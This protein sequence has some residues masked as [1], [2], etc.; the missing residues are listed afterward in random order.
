M[1]CVFLLA[2]WSTNGL[3][4][5][6]N[7]LY[8]LDTKFNNKDFSSILA[9]TLWHFVCTQPDLWH[10]RIGHRS[11][12]KLELLNKIASFVWCNK[13][14]HCDVCPI[15]KRK[16]YPFPLA[17]I[18]LHSLLILFIVT[19]GVPFLLLLWKVINISLQ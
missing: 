15:A 14:T 4:K 8:L 3:G 5:E 17:I 12:G 2:L 19:C 9:F 16:G 11:S 7:G 10:F 13:T 6:Q 18:F 1:C